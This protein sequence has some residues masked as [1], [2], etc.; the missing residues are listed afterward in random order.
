MKLVCDK[1][2]TTEE[3]SSVTSEAAVICAITVSGEAI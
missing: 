2:G 1:S 3:G